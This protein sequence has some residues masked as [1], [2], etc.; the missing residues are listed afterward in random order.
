MDE[1]TEYATEK[2]TACIYAAL[3]WPNN[4]LRLPNN[5][6]TDQWRFVIRSS[7]L[8]LRNYCAENRGWYQPRRSNTP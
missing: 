4:D 6:P 5:E 3:R 8:L 7:H 2:L 1:E